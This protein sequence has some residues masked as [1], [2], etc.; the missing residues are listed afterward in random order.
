VFL[1]ARP[2]RVGTVRLD[3]SAM[4]LVTR[5]LVAHKPARSGRPAQLIDL[6]SVG[7]ELSVVLVVARAGDRL[8]PVLAD[9]ADTLSGELEA[10]DLFVVDHGTGDHGPAVVDGWSV[11]VPEIRGIWV[12]SQVTFHEAV[13]V[14]LENTRHR[15]VLL[16]DLRSRI[17][18][19]QVSELLPWLNRVDL[20]IGRSRR[21]TTSPARSLWRRWCLGRRVPELEPA[22]VLL[23]E[24][25]L[26]MLETIPA[27]L[28]FDAALSLLAAR[29]GLAWCQVSVDGPSVPP[30]KSALRSTL[31]WWRVRRAAR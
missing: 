24:R 26:D 4:S 23:G 3:W 29:S 20:V 21:A 8:A 13:H 18:L 2:P 14:G 9:A 28:D 17:P 31:D 6:P 5:P 1:G 10:W 25:A 12:G 15:T 7:A 19:G 16:A 30:R 22:F 11:E 27:E